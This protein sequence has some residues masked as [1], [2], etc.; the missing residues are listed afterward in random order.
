MFIPTLLSPD[1]SVTQKDN[2]D[3]L[4]SNFSYNPDTYYFL[5]VGDLKNYS[6]NYFVRE[7][8]ARR[9]NKQNVQF[10]AIVPDVCVQY[11]Y[12]NILVINPVATEDM[13]ANHTFSGL[14]T[15]PRMSCR[16]K[17]STFMGAV[18][19]SE[20]IRLLIN[21]IL[22]HQNQLYVNL[23]ESMVE[24]TLDSIDGVSILG[25][26]KDIAKQF[27]DKVFQRKNLSDIVPLI[28]GF[29]CSSREDLLQ[30]TAGLWDSWKDGVFVSSA[31]SA[32]GANSAVTRCQ[33]DVEQEFS[34]ESCDYLVTKYIPHDLD[35][36]VLAV[37]ANEDDVF[38]AG[39]ADQVIQDGNRFVGST[40]PT[41]ATK[42]Q[43]QLLR[44]YTI[45]IGKELGKAGYRG[46]FG[47]D[48]LIDKEGDIRFLEINARKQGTTLEFCFT[49]EQTLPEGSPML[50]ELEYYAVTENRFPPNTVEMNGNHRSIHWGTYNYKL[51]SKQLTTGYIPQN[52]YERETFKKIAHKELIK[53][54]AILEHL[55]TNFL[56]QP[57]TFLARV[58]SV[59]RCAEDVSEGLCQGVGFI[60][61]TIT[62]A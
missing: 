11:N 16:L 49:M 46:I 58:V 30:T 32:G 14:T 50:P 34:D 1:T 22:E 9:L 54:F 47:C 12:A 48:Y 56:V 20:T 21:T 38:I 43:Q 39:I 3:I 52:P 6:L 36:T 60:K 7:T 28:E 62:E 5:Y 23:Y 15:P 51:T 35:P 8:L 61:Q 41:V 42:K 53:D 29:C 4:F 25:P 31:Y 10:I 24:M 26:D 45:A 37:V 13:I 57:G 19:K 59:A 2:G 55:G 17:S 44:N 18:S 27:N 40:F 33:Q